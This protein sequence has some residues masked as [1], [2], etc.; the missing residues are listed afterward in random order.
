MSEGSQQSLSTAM[1][2]LPFANEL[3]HLA[4]MLQWLLKYLLFLSLE[5]CSVTFA[6]EFCISALSVA[7][8]DFCSPGVEHPSGETFPKGLF[9]KSSI[10]EKLL[11]S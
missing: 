1:L 6:S 7:Q 4:S 8:S 9:L 10:F 3:S 5:S 11:T 2:C